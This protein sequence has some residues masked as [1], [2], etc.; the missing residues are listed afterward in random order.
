MTLNSSSLILLCSLLMV[1]CPGRPPAKA[2]TDSERIS[3]L[4]NRFF[5]DLARKDLDAAMSQWSPG[6]PSYVPARE[7]L[8]RLFAPNRLRIG[9]AGPI[10]IVPSGRDHA[11]AYCEMTFD[12][13]DDVSGKPV[14]GFGR[15][16]K[17]LDWV[18][19]EGSWHISRYAPV[20][21]ELADALIS[22]TSAEARKLLLS[23]SASP[24]ISDLVDI[25]TVAAARAAANANPEEAF[26][27][28]DLAIDVATFFASSNNGGIAL[29][30]ANLRKAGILRG[31]SQ[32]TAALSLAEYS[33]DLFHKANYPRGEAKAHDVI[34]SLYR[35]GANLNDA[36]SE[37]NKS[38]EIARKISERA[39]QASALS[40]LGEISRLQKKLDQ[41]LDFF[42]QSLAIS[43]A[44][45]NRPGQV[46]DLMNIANVLQME[47]KNRKAMWIYRECIDIDRDLNDKEGE[48][49]DWGNLGTTLDATGHSR[50]ALEAL[51][52]GL[53][54]DRQS[55]DRRGV[56][57]S[58]M[59]IGIVLME[60]GRI[61]D[62]IEH[63]SGSLELARAIPDP[64]RKMEALLNR[65]GAYQRRNEYGKAL[66]DFQE[67]LQ[68][69]SGDPANQALAMAAIGGVYSY[70][71]RFTEA[72]ESFR[73]AQPVFARFN[74]K[75]EE[76]VTLQNMASVQQNLGNDDEAVAD[77][78]ESLKISDISGEVII[79][80]N[81]AELY[82][83]AGNFRAAIQSARK[84]L[85][86]AHDKQI[87]SAEAMNALALANALQSNGDRN[88]A[89]RYL[90][91][92]LRLAEQVGSRE[93]STGA[94]ISLGSLENSENHWREA[95]SDCDRAIGVVES[96]RSSLG[97]PS[98]QMGFFGVNQKP[99]HCLIDALLAANQNE[100][101]LRVAERARA[102][103][104]IELLDR[105]KV[106]IYKELSGN[107]R[108]KLEDLDRQVMEIES[109]QAPL[110]NAKR[111]LELARQ[112]RD[113]FKQIVYMKTPGLAVKRGDAEPIEFGE[114]KSL[115]PNQHTALLEYV[116]EDDQSWLFVIR[117]AGELVVHPLK[118]GR[119]KINKLTA[120]YYERLRMNGVLDKNSDASDLY[121]L[122]LAPAE[123]E[124]ADVSIIGIV[125]DGNLWLVPFS[126]LRAP[127]GQYLIENKAIY[128]APSLTALRAME[129]L[130][131]SRR[132]AFEARFKSGSPAFLLVGNPN[133]NLSGPANRLNCDA[134]RDIPGTGTEVHA[135]Y[136]LLG[137]RGNLLLGKDATEAAVKKEVGKFPVIHFATHGCFNAANPMYS[138]II[139][140]E[141]P[142]A[143]EDGFW[144]AREIAE[145]DLTAELVVLSACD[146][147]RGDIVGGEGVVGLSWA[148]FVAGSPASLLASWRVD[149]KS[150]PQFMTQFYQEWGVNSARQSL[151]SKAVALQRAQVAM[152][153]VNAHP[154]YWAPFVL[155]GAP[156]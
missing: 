115:L 104:L 58:L 8:R 129:R 76:S 113:N 43:R 111:A 47:N 15:K 79:R 108:R 39:I 55:D 19:L 117:G 83:S 141:S 90:S 77:Y 16:K 62:A 60:T 53:E 64:A 127:N 11:R 48:A 88:E 136:G 9:D 61:P 69:S 25:L 50:E 100:E 59:N 107:D 123:K 74:M 57:T 37:S 67:L 110:P 12:V 144:E 4:T 138:G 98:L 70:E 130:A 120:D 65:G 24:D 23:A 63:F 33:R 97:D 102:R 86:L 153:R 116:I 34:G 14:E 30:W 78:Q 46:V 137:A 45:G 80:S 128:Y 146:T 54:L 71:G 68:L 94:Y 89:R 154:H 119:K 140:S 29:G 66:A 49:T 126:A 75:L 27:L 93:V 44:L 150:T 1:S 152:M 26:R 132:P 18:K 40:N 38:L 134:N 32:D 133:L 42:G 35:L 17:F 91:D 156:R 41:A 145:Q 5:S 155:I 142:G 84:G 6:S 124:L 148:L 28:S 31:R 73:A 7:E 131:E 52:K 112:T 122:L 139:L 118:F 106:D 3:R 22:K 72:M 87:P 109:A 56:A 125:P 21:A 51:N 36:S 96:V 143:A 95:V 2:E 82:R 103:T 121:N 85:Q 99:Y 147:A 135:L 13:R 81:L 105:G 20:E 151:Q 149:D 101:A 92:A 114:L 10:R